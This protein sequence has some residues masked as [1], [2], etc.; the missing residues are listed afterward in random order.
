[1]TTQLLQNKLK[2]FIGLS[3]FIFAL[4]LIG[5]WFTNSLALLSDAGHVLID[6]LALVLAYIGTV[7]AQRAANKQFTYGYRRA[8]IFSALINSVILIAVT[9]YIAYESYNRF[10]S[11]EPIKS[12]G[13]L[14][15]SIIGLVANMYVLVKMHRDEKENMNI[16]GAY[17]HVLTDTL[18]SI[19]VI[20]AAILIMV[21]GN[22][23]FD[24]LISIVIAIIILA[25]SLR[26]MRDA[27]KI[28]M[29]A[30]PEGI[31]IAHVQNDMVAIAGVKDVHDLHVWSI[32][33]ELKAC[34]AHVFLDANTTAEANKI[35]KNI[36][37]LLEEKYHIT[38]TTIQSECDECISKHDTHVPKKS[39][40][41]DH[42]H[43]E[44]NE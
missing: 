22:Y 2:I 42:Q 17:L 25:S 35:I 30:T 15:I 34:S 41:H 27:G 24:P 7:F 40:R 19:G 32:S 6:V 1:M 29:E 13:M 33:S 44:V 3:I 4:E 31:D 11:P 9:I 23:L 12:G 38:H 43:S 20:I 28:L 37:H 8:E 5:G 16:K 14:V 39:I 21:T 26:L 18:S 10:V 36:N